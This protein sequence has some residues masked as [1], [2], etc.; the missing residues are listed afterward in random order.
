MLTNSSPQPREDH[1]RPPREPMTCRN[2]G[3]EG[4]KASDCTEERKPKC[5]NCD[6]IGHMSKECSKPRDYSRVQC[7]NCQEC[8]YFE[9]VQ[10]EMTD[11]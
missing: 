6:E 8:E 5:R 2:C 4:H 7:R 10:R 11:T 9:S 1:D 3:G